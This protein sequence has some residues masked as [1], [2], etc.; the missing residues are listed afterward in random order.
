MQGQRPFARVVCGGIGQGRGSA[1]RLGG[2]MPGAAAM[3]AKRRGRSPLSFVCLQ[4]CLQDSG[5]APLGAWYSYVCK[6][7]GQLPSEPCM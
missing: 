6:K 4:L 7:Q 5:A 1:P 2:V 3:F